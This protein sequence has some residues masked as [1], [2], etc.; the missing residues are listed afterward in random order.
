ML[1]CKIFMLTRHL[2]I[3]LKIDHENVLFNAIQI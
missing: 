3:C 2:L 1:T